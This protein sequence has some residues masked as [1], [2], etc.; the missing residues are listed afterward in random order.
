VPRPR[1]SAEGLRPGPFLNLFTASQLTNLLIQKEL[2][3]VGLRAPWLGVLHLVWLNE[4]LTP[5][6]L[7]AL[8][9][10]RPTTLRDAVDALIERGLVERKPN[11]S[12]RR[13][14]FLNVTDEGERVSIEAMQATHNAYERLKPHLGWPVMEIDPRLE[15]LIAALQEALSLR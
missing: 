12:D 10:V 1:R 3:A 7:E 6:R 13:S 5:S 4:P 9:G 8:S 2:D 14:T 11:P 15:D